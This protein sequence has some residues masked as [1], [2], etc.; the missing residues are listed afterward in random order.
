MSR[1]L[2]ENVFYER[3]DFARVT[4]ALD[5]RSP[6][7]LA[8]AT[9]VVRL[10][11]VIR[12]YSFKA[13]GGLWRDTYLG[14]EGDTISGSEAYPNALRTRKTWPMPFRNDSG[15]R[16]LFR[17]AGN[18]FTTN[19]DAVD[20]PSPPGSPAPTPTPATPGQPTPTAPAEPVPLPPLPPPPAIQ[21]FTW[22]EVVGAA[23]AGRW[24]RRLT[25]PTTW[26][27]TYSAGS[28]TARTVAMLEE[29]GILRRVQAADFESDE[30]T[31]F[32][33]YVIPDPADLAPGETL[34][35]P[36]EFS[37]DPP[38]AGQWVQIAENGRRRWVPLQPFACP[39]A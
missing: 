32:D 11:P 21:T 36:P 33:W 2:Q 14:F 8:T 37:P 29:N 31:A 22:W 6:T 25:W 39:T 9:L 27:L 15:V 30:F 35:V 18:P 28:G 24:V 20:A 13:G 10:G 17:A 26:R 7:Q 3:D 23:M 12:E 5:S 19:I 34:P 1:R 4:A 38:P 16:F